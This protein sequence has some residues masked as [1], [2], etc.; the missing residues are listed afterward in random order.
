MTELFDTQE[1]R[2]EAI[3]KFTNLK[4]DP[5]WQLVCKILDAN[6]EVI[7]KKIL[8]G[9]PDET[10]EYIDTLRD[11]LMAFKNFRDTPDQMIK[12]LTSGEPDQ[13][14]LDPFTTLDELKEARKNLIP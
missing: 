11:R 9:V 6:I 14:S 8:E 2:N 4:N 12:K 1:K 13:P 7:T 10:K 3:A 5:G